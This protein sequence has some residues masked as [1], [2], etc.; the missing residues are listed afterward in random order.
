MLHFICMI[1]Y[2]NDTNINLFVLLLFD[3]VRC[4]IQK[5]LKKDLTR[6]AFYSYIWSK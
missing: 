3:G 1:L 4:N 6:M 2:D 5:K